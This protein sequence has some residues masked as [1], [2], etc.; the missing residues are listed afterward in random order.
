MG[1][2]RRVT[3][4]PWSC[5]VDGYCMQLQGVFASLSD[6]KNMIKPSETNQEKRAFWD[7]R[8]LLPNLPG[9][10]RMIEAVLK[11]ACGLRKC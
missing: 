10:V 3:K 2:F 4:A 11:N 9:I 8:K 7:F 5:A 1:D 6:N